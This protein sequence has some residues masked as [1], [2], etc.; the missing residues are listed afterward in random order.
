MP[1]FVPTH[2]PG[3]ETRTFKT[4]CINP[5]CRRTVYSFSCSCESRVF[6]DKK[7]PPWPK[8]ECPELRYA[9]LQEEGHS[10]ES[11]RFAL[12]MEERRMGREV[13]ARLAEKMQRDVKVEAARKTTLKP[14]IYTEVLPEEPSD[15]PGTVMAIE[16]NINTPKL[17]GLQSTPIARLLLGKLGRGRWH[18]MHVR[19][20]GAGSLDIVG[21]MFPLIRAERVR[22]LGIKVGSRVL[23]SVE[24]YAPPGQRPFLIGTEVSLRPT[25]R[26]EPT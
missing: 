7:G 18:R 4:R 22:D 3:C 14:T 12:E 25:T 5:Y 24:P 8:H 15:F 23:V 10:A 21:Q 6:F 17:V 13:P 20:E 16:R 11:A 19:E 2:R 1:G 9:T 26:R